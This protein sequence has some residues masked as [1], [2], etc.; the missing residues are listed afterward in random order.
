V[1]EGEWV[2][3]SRIGGSGH[4]PSKVVRLAHDHMAS[5]IALDI[6]IG[7]RKAGAPFRNHL[8]ILAAAPESTRQQK[9]PLKIP[10]TVA[11][12]FTFVEPDALFAIGRNVFAL[13]ADRGTESITTVIRRKIL[14]YREIVATGVIDDYLGVDNLKVLFATRSE[15]RLRA[16]MRE[17]AAIARNAKSTMFAFRAEPTFGDFLKAPTPTGRLFVEPWA[18]V[19]HPD[20]VLASVATT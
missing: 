17:L 15:K 2:A 19:G 1:P 12:E 10:V 8:E 9:R 14:A 4:S 6:E 20:L 5:D 11:G 3:N 16:V 13:E 18:R 7:A